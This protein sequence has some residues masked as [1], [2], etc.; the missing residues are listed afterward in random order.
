MKVQIHMYKELFWKPPF[1][2]IVVPKF[3]YNKHHPW[4]WTPKKNKSPKCQVSNGEYI[5][6]MSLNHG[7]FLLWTWSQILWK[8]IAWMS[9][10]QVTKIKGSKNRHK[11]D[12]ILKV[13]SHSRV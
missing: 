8:C 4:A 12:N 7:P 13:E 2:Q 3:Y 5:P 9:Q 10:L 11:V 6:P 1:L